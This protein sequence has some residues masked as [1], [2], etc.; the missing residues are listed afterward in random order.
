M[1]KKKRDNIKHTGPA[2]FEG[3]TQTEFSPIPSLTPVDIAMEGNLEA[4]ADMSIP[5]TPDVDGQQTPVIPLMKEVTRSDI[6]LEE[7]DFDDD[8]QPRYNNQMI[9]EDVVVAI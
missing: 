5:P 1:N 2:Y 7:Y 6:Q 8:D 9:D 4:I 3:G